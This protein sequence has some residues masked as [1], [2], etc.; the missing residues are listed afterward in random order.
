MYLCAT[1]PG[2]YNDKLVNQ[3]ALAQARPAMMNRHTSSSSFEVIGKSFCMC[4][5]TSSRQYIQSA[6]LTAI[7]YKNI[8]D[9]FVTLRKRCF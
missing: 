2:L 6:N 3:C 1:N 4:V 9:L 7:Q 8:E 5:E